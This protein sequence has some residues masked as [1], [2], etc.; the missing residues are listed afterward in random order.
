MKGLHFLG[1]TCFSR[2]SLPVLFRKTARQSRLL[3]LF[4][5][6]SIRPGSREEKKVWQAT[7]SIDIFYYLEFLSTSLDE[8]NT[9][10]ET[11]EIGLEK[12]VLLAAPVSSAYD[13]AVE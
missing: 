4:L 13:V 11:P 1:L 3:F 8:P 6:R 12:H 5:I 10:R 7:P 9:L 2:V